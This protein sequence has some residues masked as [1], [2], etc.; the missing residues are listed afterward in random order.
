MLW[1]LMP[2]LLVFQKSSCILI[3]VLTI[4]NA[5]THLK[6][7]DLNNSGRRVGTILEYR[8]LET[9]IIQLY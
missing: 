1:V 3:H 9:F 2:L 7:L 5:K 4:T 8:Y 6:G